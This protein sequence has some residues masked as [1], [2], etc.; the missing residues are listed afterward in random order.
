MNQLKEMISENLKIIFTE[1]SSL[2]KDFDVLLKSHDSNVNKMQKELSNVVLKATDDTK[3]KAN[4][5]LEQSIEQLVKEFFEGSTRLQERFSTLAYELS[6]VV[7]NSIV[8]INELIGNSINE[9]KSLIEENQEKISEEFKTN[10]ELI[11]QTFEETEKRDA[12]LLTKTKD[13][14]NNA[15]SQL[16]E[17][18]Q[19]SDFQEL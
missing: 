4:E 3:I 17:A 18:N 8:S 15:I 19:T 2:K 16:K 12:E 7:N 6:D 1:I 13:Q 10:I 9:A 14:L 11:S 5:L